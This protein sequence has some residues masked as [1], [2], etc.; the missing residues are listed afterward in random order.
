LLNQ[1][2]V[3]PFTCKFAGKIPVKTFKKPVK[4]KLKFYL[5]QHAPIILYSSLYF[6]RIFVIMVGSV[7]KKG[8]VISL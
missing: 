7:R 3:P 1:F 5:H 6:S 2:G 4:E 8:E